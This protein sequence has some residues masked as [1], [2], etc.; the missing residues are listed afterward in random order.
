MAA[1][2]VTGA[3]ILEHVAKDDP[4]TPDEEWADKCA[5]AVE[6]VIAHRLEGITLGAGAEAELE[7][8]G[9]QD[10]AACYLSR[11]SPHGIQSIGPDGDIV[12]LGRSIV[13]EL[14][15]VFQTYAGPGIG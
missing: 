11:K 4:S 1:P 9:L 5:A 3:L 15:P 6:S 7:V 12:R 10:G 13:R 8:A 14:E 2:Y